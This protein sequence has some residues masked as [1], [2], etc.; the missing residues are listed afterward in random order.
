MDTDEDKL[1]QL[2]EKVI[3]CAFTVSNRL[4]CGFLEK[5][6]E[7]ALAHELRKAGLAVQQQH[8]ILVRYDGIV[9]GDYVA[10]L[11][12]EGS[13]IVELKA[14]KDLDDVHS[15]Q[16][17]NYVFATGLPVCLLL[18][19]GKPRLQIKPFRGKQETNL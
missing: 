12:V 1:N 19:F 13:V 17:L 8:P 6:Y 7:N 5:V 15:A 18:N 14:C 2:T 4:G 16:C 11:I 3:G 10:D 9:V